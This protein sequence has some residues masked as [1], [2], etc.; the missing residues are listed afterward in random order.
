MN[1]QNT[2]RIS[3]TVPSK[4]KEALESLAAERGMS[5]SQTVKSLLERGLIEEAYVEMGGEIFGR[6]PSGEIRTFV[7]RPLNWIKKSVNGKYQSTGW[8]VRV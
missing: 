7:S 3:V 6:D 8:Y 5:L 4:T 1:R 2:D